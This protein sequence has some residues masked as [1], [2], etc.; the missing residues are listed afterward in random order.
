MNAHDINTRINLTFQCCIDG[1]ELECKATRSAPPNILLEYEA[2]M[3]FCQ[4]RRCIA[5][6]TCNVTVFQVATTATAATTTAT[7]TAAV[8]ATES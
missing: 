5:L 6:F 8:A 7:T 1:S 4:N 2:A 3:E